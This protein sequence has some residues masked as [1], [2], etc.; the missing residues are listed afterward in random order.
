MFNTII[1]YN[2]EQ[3]Y[4]PVTFG[5]LTIEEVKNNLIR[6]QKRDKTIRLYCKNNDINLLE[7]PYFYNDSKI[8]KEITKFSKRIKNGK[9]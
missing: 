3:H 8:K 2:G 9:N 7:I 1:K 4:K 5:N 6:Q